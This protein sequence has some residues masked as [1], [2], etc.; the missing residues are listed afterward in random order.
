MRHVRLDRQDECLL[1]RSVEKPHF[2]G[3]VTTMPRGG[4]TVKTVDDAHRLLVDEHGWQGILDVGKQEAVLGVLSAQPWRVPWY[5]I[6]E[7]HRDLC[8]TTA[9]KTVKPRIGL[10]MTMYW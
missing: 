4:Q 8:R 3:R 9:D 6:G 7:R 1:R 2:Y 10:L 5:Q